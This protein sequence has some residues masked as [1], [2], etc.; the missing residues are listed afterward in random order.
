MALPIV[1]ATAGYLIYRLERRGERQR[2]RPAGWP[3]ALGFMAL[4]NL[5][6][7]DFLLGFVLGYPGDFHRGFSHT[8]LA[9]LL[10][11]AG[12]ATVM[13]WRRGDRW[14]PSALVLAAV[15][16]SHLLVDALTID[17]RAPAGAPFFWPLSD[18]YFIFPFTFFSEI[19]IDGH[20]RLGFLASILR[21][22]TVPVLAREAVIAGAILVTFNLI[23]GR[24]QAGR[25]G[26]FETALA[27][28]SGE[29]DLA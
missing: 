26:G 12:L 10:V 18:A 27:P 11:G 3:R 8:V 24:A 23:E 15:Y 19:L 25:P 13:W 28:D 16:G 20:S 9:A 1:H 7:A 2:S 5:P 17:M 6:D 14:W 21:W 29:E 22:E 4:A